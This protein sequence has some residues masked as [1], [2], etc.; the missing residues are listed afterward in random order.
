LYADASYANDMLLQKIKIYF[1]RISPPCGEEIKRWGLMTKSSGCT[2][3]WHN[4]RSPKNLKLV[5]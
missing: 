1:S 4:R 2:R 3:E 5:T